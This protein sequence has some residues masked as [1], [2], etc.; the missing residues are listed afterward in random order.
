M[1]S[2]QK[3]INSTNLLFTS[4][5]CMVGSG[6]LLSS[7][8]ASSIAGTGAL[9]AWLI[10]G[11]MI[12]FIAYC[13]AELAILLPFSGGI[14]RYSEIT[15]GKLASFLIGWGA[16]LSCV[17]AAPTEVE[18]VLRYLSDIYPNLVNPINNDIHL[19]LNGSLVAIV[20]LAVFTVINLKG[21]RLLIKYNRI[22]AIWKLAIPTIVIILLLPHTQP[23]VVFEGHQPWDWPDV[24][25]A[26]AEIVVFSFLGFREAT[27]L[28]AETKNPRKSMPI[29][30]VGSVLICTVLYMGL[31]YVFLGH[32]FTVSSL[33]NEHSNGP[34]TQLAIKLGL[35]WLAFIIYVDVMINPCGAALMYTATTSRLTYAMSKMKCAPERFSALN[36]HGVPHYS[37]L[38]NFIVGIILMLALPG[39]KMIVKFQAMCMLFAYLTGPL[40]YLAVKTTMN[41]TPNNRLWP[42]RIYTFITLFICNIL[43]YWSGWDT[44]QSIDASL[45]IGSLIYYGYA[46]YHQHPVNESMQALWIVPHIILISVISYYGNYEGGHHLLPHGVDA[47]CIAGVSIITM[48]TAKACQ[49]P[50]EQIKLNLKTLIKQG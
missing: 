28:A 5:S 45:I 36:I 35:T 1:A 38:F 43:M 15:H 16:W 37:L 29:A 39:W 25:Q 26:L 27:S 13:F 4:I 49:Y 24:F 3:E 32:N 23:S 19:S 20:I 11:I 48:I 10:G 46:Y 6:W 9:A 41:S 50:D 8:Y 33:I 12:L 2:F 42:H 14:A 44:I 30:I 21:I 17:A 7:Y 31:Q 34:F 18:A 22:L 47:L 40:V